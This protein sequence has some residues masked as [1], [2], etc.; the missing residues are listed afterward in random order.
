M[1]YAFF[2]RRLRVRRIVKLNT[3]QK[4]ILGFWGRLESVWIRLINKARDMV[5]NSC[6]LPFYTVERVRTAIEKFK[7]SSVSSSG[8]E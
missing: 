1:Y 7:I 8:M 6:C 5:M 3:K 2:Y 4:L